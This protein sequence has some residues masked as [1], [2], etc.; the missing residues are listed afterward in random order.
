[1]CKYCSHNVVNGFAFHTVNDTDED[2]DALGNEGAYDGIEVAEDGTASLYLFF[3]TLDSD[4]DDYIIERRTE[5]AYCPFCGR[6]LN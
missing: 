6:K 3:K 5:I 1:M 4:G 2:I